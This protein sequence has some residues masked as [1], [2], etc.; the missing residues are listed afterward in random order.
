MRT[1]VV[2]ESMYGN[3]RHVA[4]EIGHGMSVI[5]NA[6]VGTTRDI[7]AEDIRNADL[8]IVGGPTHVHGMMS[9][10]S[11]R[12][13]I[14]AA[15]TDDTITLDPSVDAVALRQWIKELPKRSAGLCATF[16]TRLDKSAII[17]GSAAKDIAKRLDRHGF[18]VV[19]EPESFFVADSEGPLLE[20]EA[21]RAR[22]W[23]ETLVLRCRD[24]LTPAP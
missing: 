12:G 18:T 3:T 7:G 2:F 4:E 11:R 17:T 23:G 13:A 9:N 22:L 16:D 21:H 10:A 19:A 5:S 8:L 14:E 1:F 15:E 6:T 20:G 24:R